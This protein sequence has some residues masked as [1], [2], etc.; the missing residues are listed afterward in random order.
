MLHF[1]FD[2]DGTICFNGQY[3]EDII[4]DALDDLNKNHELIFASARPIRDLLPVVTRFKDNLLIGGNGSIISYN[5]VIQVIDYISNNDY[6]HL[7]KLIV[8]YD[9]SYI[10]D[11]AFDYSAK[12]DPS[13]L[14]YRQLDPMNLAKNVS[15]EDIEKPIKIIL[16]DIPANLYDNI[17]QRLADLG[18]NI[19]VNYHHRESNIDITARNINKYTTLK[20]LIGNRNYIGYGNDINDYDLLMNAQKSYYISQDKDID[21]D[22]DVTAVLP[23]DA[24]KI[25]LSV[26]SHLENGCDVTDS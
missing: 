21:L 5:G 14:I 16:I 9:L 17:S 23:K 2:I 1:V 19:S 22:F 20:K 18:D 7:K 10:I 8:E 15:F 11:G 13:N 26:H 4:S 25:A 3:I 24:T 6:M 12:V